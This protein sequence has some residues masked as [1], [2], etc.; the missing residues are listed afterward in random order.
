MDEEGEDVVV[1]VVVVTVAIAEEEEE[2]DVV[3]EEAD[4]AE[5]GGFP[6]DTSSPLP[7]SGSPPSC[8]EN[9]NT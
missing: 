2:E 7:W 9:N 1:V 5:T 3:V 8:N 4:E 6:G